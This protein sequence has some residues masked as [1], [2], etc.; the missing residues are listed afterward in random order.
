M[1]PLPASLTD[2]AGRFLRLLERSTEPRLQSLLCDYR[3]D[4][5]LPTPHE[6]IRALGDTT[7]AA[8]GHLCDTWRWLTLEGELSAVSDLQVMLTT[9]GVLLSV[10][11][12]VKTSTGVRIITHCPAAMAQSLPLL[13]FAQTADA[14]SQELLL[15]WN[16]YF[17]CIHGNSFR[18]RLRQLL[19]LTEA[20]QSPEF[21]GTPDWK[22]V[23]DPISQ[24]LPP[25]L[26]SPWAER[27]KKDGSGQWAVILDMPASPLN[28]PHVAPDILHQIYPY[29]LWWAADLVATLQQKFPVGSR[30]NV[31]V[32]KVP[33]E[34]APR[35]L[36]ASTLLLRDDETASQVMDLASPPWAPAS[37]L[38]LH[39]ASGLRDA[40]SVCS[41]QEIL[42][43]PRLP[44]L[45]LAVWTAAGEAATPAALGGFL[46]DDALSPLRTSSAARTTKEV[47]D[48]LV[49]GN[50]VP[51][52]VLLQFEAAVRPGPAAP[53]DG[54]L[55]KL[56]E[57][58][59]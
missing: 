48:K 7:G 18:S 20:D 16:P 17:R 24:R 47:L 4:V 29:V 3:T 8:P 59:R 28:T 14:T 55:R 51:I 50:S 10:T 31:K 9:N 56:T 52:E 53:D 2:V 46:V 40:M 19:G 27:H 12:D 13:A 25:Q 15:R 22:S 42:R 1:P 32:R 45:S 33:A 41:P 37:V 43:T 11:A 54:Q 44:E 57:Q 30:A 26:R 36:E 39:L 35:A 49:H 34:Q 21:R 5:P 6:A 23:A 58:D 38:A